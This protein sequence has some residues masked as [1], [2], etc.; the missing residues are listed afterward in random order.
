MSDYKKF[1]DELR[2]QVAGMLGGGICHRNTAGDKGKYRS[3][4]CT[5]YLPQEY[6]RHGTPVL[7]SYTAV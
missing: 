4:R 5:H 2:I 6:G 3:H 1:L 7:L